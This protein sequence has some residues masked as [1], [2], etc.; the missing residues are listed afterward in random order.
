MSII[1]RFKLS[2]IKP[3]GSVVQGLSAKF[4]IKNFPL[5]ILFVFLAM[6]YISVRYDCITAMETVS[7]LKTRLA[8]THTEAQRERSLYMS[9]TC[10]SA[11]QQ[12]VDALNL[13][14]HIQERPPYRISLS[15]SSP[16]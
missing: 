2:G 4:F 11:M 14:L 7:Q 8:I 5:I 6:A 12:R 3:D 10:E 15:E 1:N 16:H 9:A 13:G